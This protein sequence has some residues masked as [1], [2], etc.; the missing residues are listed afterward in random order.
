ME[1]RLRD[2][3]PVEDFKRAV[4]RRDA[5]ALRHV[6][7]TEPSVRAAIN[8]PLFGFESPALVSVA[9]DSDTA[10]LDVLLEFG[11]DPDRK[12][13]WWAGGFHP[14]Y[15][16]SDP[17]AARLIAAG[18]TIDACAAA[19]LGRVDILEQLVAEEPARV[20][21]R[22]GDGQMPLHFARS[23]AVIDFLLAHGADIDARDIDHRSTAAEWMIGDRTELARYLVDRGATA[24]IFLA[25]ALGRTDLVTRMLE[26]DRGLLALRTGQGDYD[27]K[28]PSSYQIYVWTIG[29]NLTPLQTA[30]KFGHPDT[31]EAMLR[32]ATPAQALLAA[33]NRGLR[34]EALAIIK[35]NPG[36]VASLGPH[37]RRALTDE[38]WA[39]NAPAVRL[40]LELGFDPSVPSGVDGKGGNA[41]HCAAWEGSVECVEAI[42]NTRAGRALVNSREGTFNGVPLGWC[43]HGSVHCTKPRADHPAVARLLISAGARIEG[44]V[45]TWDASAAVRAVLRDAERKA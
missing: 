26:R 6:L 40:M 18:A 35:Q 21:E 12:S 38:A 41:L 16:A 8:E 24:D 42:L 1:G 4:H 13:S 22:G 43:A 5:G 32:Y 44:D 31:V 39:A 7:A 30:A 29:A 33:C 28:K 9:G 37:D 25:A 17:A 3:I 10:L 45:A 11:A 23:R 19:R 15:G 34:D 2:A 14:L 27:E 20:Q 36:I